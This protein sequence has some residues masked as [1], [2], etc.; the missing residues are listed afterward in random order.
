ME[1][2]LTERSYLIDGK[3]IT[4]RPLSFFEAMQLPDLIGKIV[5]ALPESKEES[6]DYPKIF[7]ALRDEIQILF[8]RCADLKPE[9]FQNVPMEFGMEMLADWVEANLSENFIKALQRALDAGKRISTGFL[10][11]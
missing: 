4:V 10:K 7:M 1:S 3:T 6:M 8:C 5:K 2:I 9:D 11:P